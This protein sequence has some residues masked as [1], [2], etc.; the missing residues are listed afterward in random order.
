MENMEAS[1]RF[2]NSQTSRYEILLDNLFS[3][4]HDEKKE[5]GA[6]DERATD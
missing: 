6:W 1:S 3:M 2:W 5:R 4:G